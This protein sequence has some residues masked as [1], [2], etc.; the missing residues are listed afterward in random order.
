[1]R[2]SPDMGAVVLWILSLGFLLVATV[3]LAERFAPAKPLTTAVEIP[4]TPPTLVSDLTNDLA[5]CQA[6]NRALQSM[7]PPH[8]PQKPQ[9]TERPRSLPLTRGDYYRSY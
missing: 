6:K 8:W 9:V 4:P 7:E 3:S 1:M 2:H 5:E